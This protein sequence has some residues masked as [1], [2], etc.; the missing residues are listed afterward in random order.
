M[1]YIVIRQTTDWGNEAVVH[2]QLP[3]RFRGKVALWNATFNLP[4][5]VFR[6]ELARIARLSLSRVADAV[7]VPRAEVPAGAILVP[8]DDDDWFAPGLATALE[9]AVDGEHVGYYWPSA[10]VELPISRG[11]RLGLIRRAIF[12][13]TS[14][15]WLC[16]TNNYAL[17]MGS[18]TATLINSHVTASQWFIANPG[19]VKRLGDRLSVMNR[20]L[21]SQTSFWSVKS[22]GDLVRKFHR[23]RRLYERRVAPDL[24][25]C[26]PYVAMMRDV[27]NALTLRT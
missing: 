27:M 25:W 17:A 7:Y 5:H 9:A 6:L 19:A 18:E 3:E 13:S 22:Q 21:A 23:Y 2:A 15:K 12:P 24:A 11:H 8:T 14:P 20:T 16:T 4:Y 26:E 10:F 1:I